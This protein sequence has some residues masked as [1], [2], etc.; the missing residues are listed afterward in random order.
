M[1]MQDRKIEELLETVFTEREV[2][3]NA[4]LGVLANAGQHAGERGEGDLA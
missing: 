2:G 4:S 1:T 3:R